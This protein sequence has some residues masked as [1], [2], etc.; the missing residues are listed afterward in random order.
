MS[1][2]NSRRDRAHTRFWQDRLL[3]LMGVFVVFAA[4]FFAGMS[5]YE[6]RD[7]YERVEHEPFPL[8][9]SFA[10]FEESMG[11]EVPRDLAYLRFKA[12]ALLEADALKRRY[13]QA[14]S[15][16]LARVWTR[17]LGFLTGMLL[18]LIGAA[19]ILGKLRYEGTHLETEIEG[20][21]GTL[22]SSSPGIIL[23]VLGTGLMALTISIPFGVETYDV[24]TYLR[25]ESAASH[26]ESVLPQTRTRDLEMMEEDLFGSPTNRTG[27]DD[28]TGDADRAEGE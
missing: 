5:V 9:K 12:S 20:T 10:E 3:P 15:T 28:G 8:D 4:L 14:N 17:Q 27:L 23:A 19:F 18:S 25:A 26:S 6:L 22:K 21:K 7:L 2:S 11:G 24:N 16:M 1:S 13:H